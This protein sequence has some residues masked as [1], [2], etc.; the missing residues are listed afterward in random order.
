MKRKVLSRRYENLF[1]ELMI[2]AILL[3]LLPAL[4]RAASF[5]EFVTP[6]PDSSPADIAIDSKGNIWFTEINA[7]KIGKLVPSEA[8]PGTSKGITEYDVPEA[9]G[10][11]YFIMVA[12]NDKIYFSELDGN[13][14]GQLDPATGKIKEFAI[15]TL[16]SEP[17]NMR[18]DEQGNIWFV[19]FE[20]QK[21]GKLNPATGAIKEYRIKEG[22][23]HDLTLAH[24][25]VWYTMGG[26]FWAQII[27]DKIGA[28][29]MQTGEFTELE[30][31]PKKSTPHGITKGA[32]GT[33]WFSLHF[34]KKISRL[35]FSKGNPPAVVNYDAGDMVQT[36]HDLV[37]D[38]KRGWIWFTDD[39]GSL[40]GRLDIA[41]AKPDTAEGF[42]IFK[43]PTPKAHPYQL[44][45]DKDGNV[46]F[47]EM[48][49]YFRGRFQN[50]I[51]KLI[52]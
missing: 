16:K 31:Q 44:A 13:K 30:I 23:P 4:A 32:D 24:G 25:K 52:P 22:Y 10:K 3:T 18:E 8:E 11:P 28:L 46:W 19:E 9:K 26:K 48:G 1:Y 49:A 43:I 17:H 14:I 2:A 34:G 40:I 29:D 38:D 5:E 21:I 47:T 27:Y 41:K 12:S 42:D 51:G 33:I 20:G 36:P 37:V 45:L 15:P 6:T 39:H 7:N 50:K 35:D